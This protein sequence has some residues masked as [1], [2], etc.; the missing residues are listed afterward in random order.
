MYFTRLSTLIVT[1]LSI[2]LQA[3]AQLPPNQPEQDCPNA[4]PVCQDIYVQ[5]NSYQGEGLMPNEINSAFSC[6]GTA[7]NND[8]WY[9]LTVQSSG[10]LC[11][12]VSP[13]NGN[14]DYDWAVYNLTN[15]TCAD[16]ATNPALEVSCNFAPNLGCG[17]VTGPN[18]QNANPFSP[19]A[20]QNENCINVVIGETYVINVS[21]YSSTASGYV[22]DFTA[23]SAQ[24]FDNIPPELESISV[25]CGA[26][27]ID[28]TFSENIVCSSVDLTDFT[29]T[30]PGGPYTI[31]SVV[32]AN[33]TA[34]FDFERDFTIQTTPNISTTGVFQLAL[35]DT[36]V[37]NCG[38]V[39]VFDSLSFTAANAIISITASPDSV[40]VGNMSTLST[41]VS[42]DPNY[43]FVWTPGGATTPTIDVSPAVTTTYSVTATDNNN[44]VSVGTTTVHIA[45]NPTSTF[46]VANTQPCTGDSVLITYS[47]TAPPSANY[48][49][50]F[51]GAGAAPGTGQGPHLVSWAS[52]TST[53]V[54]LSV[55]DGACGSPLTTTPI[56]VSQTPDA[57]ISLSDTT[58]CG[59]DVVTLTHT[60]SASPTA[61]YNWTFSGANA[62]PGTGGSV[63]SMT[64]PA[65]GTYPLSLS[66][67]DGNCTSPLEVDTVEAFEVPI[68]TFSAVP[69][70]VCT[71]ESTTL[72][73]TGGNAT[74]GASFTW[75]FDGGLAVPGT[76]PGP[77]V[78]TWPT[79]GP[80]VVRLNIEENGCVGVETSVNITVGVSPTTDYSA[81][82][83]CANS[84]TDFTDLSSI[85][86][87]N[88]IGWDWDFDDP[89]SG[90]S[91]VSTLQNPNHT[92]T[93]AGS[94]DVILVTTSSD[95]CKDTLTQAVTVTP[96]PV[97]DYL[98]QNECDGNAVQF[99]DASTIDPG[100]S[101]D[102]WAW[103]F[104]DGNNANTQNTNHIYTGFGSFDVT[105]T[106]TSD[107][108]CVNSTTQNITV[109]PNPTATFDYNS[110]CE[111]LATTFTSTSTVGGNDMVD[112]WDWD[113]GD[114]GSGANNTATGLSAPNHTYIN[115]G[116]YNVTLIA[117]TNNGCK[118]TLNELIS[119]YERPVADFFYD[120]KCVDQN[121]T[122]N[123]V[124]QIPTGTNISSWDWAFGDG[125]SSGSS[126]PVHRYNTSGPGTYP[127]TLIIV[128][129]EGCA[130]TVTK[131]VI[132]NPRPL[133]IFSH[134]TECLGDPTEFTDESSIS[135]GQIIDWQWD[136]GDGSTSSD[137]SPT[138]TYPEPGIHRVTL[139]LT[140]DSG[141]V[142][143]TVRNVTVYAPPPEPVIQ[144][145]SICLGEEA[146]LTVYAPSDIEVHWFDSPTSTTP[147]FSG[148]FYL[149]PKL[150]SDQTFY[151]TT[152]SGR[153]C[154]TLT[155]APIQAIV[156]GDQ[157]AEIQASEQT[158][159]LPLAFVEFN[160]TDTA[161]YAA[162]LWDFGDG[163]TSTEPEPAHQ[164][165]YAGIYD[166]QLTA[167][168]INGCETNASY[169][170]EVKRLVNLYVPSAFTPNGDG[171]N[172]LLHIGHSGLITFQFQ[173]FNRWNKLV[174]ESDNPDFEWDGLY[175]GKTLPDG[176]Y[177]YRVKALSFD[178][179]EV[180]ESGT[181]TIVR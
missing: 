68:T 146:I 42:S 107:N 115:G 140:S 50:D 33:C 133:P 156:F 113:F 16:I 131:N 155:P 27:S 75:D 159:F 38:N 145:D 60:G 7:E 88:I 162:W 36:V 67:T 130:D 13:A 177:V 55:L 70:L 66:I 39:G 92:Y 179:N 19:C 123:D 63:Q 147:F 104:G 108:G 176:V 18:G 84:P 124:S 134:T 10:Q 34:G 166:V 44:C 170:V 122:F 90:T 11:F 178:G 112:D 43:T 151:I 64:F 143:Q 153:Q 24:V 81:T 165:Q 8:T 105:L 94:Y 79:T 1:F 102:N 118:D 28:V 29:L 109:Y 117:T 172:D 40:C 74:S 35:V 116:Q 96:I 139:V 135:S 72:T 69:S 103:E 160:T 49:W 129:N 106:V 89:S 142:H 4:I 25:P 163:E 80:K 119:V 53:N 138:Y 136:F 150:L 45:P 169:P 93:Q 15:A 83:A 120:N 149:T 62:S 86:G 148:N 144:D 51:G 95:G 171:H 157:Q 99:N 77:H 154:S 5:P 56:T 141:C 111:G 167:T 48:T 164:Y 2:Y 87:S 158:V 23:S 71:G 12:S 59:S 97:A 46:N 126:R 47:G 161:A 127:A 65:A 20:G 98:T 175:E 173:V 52:V 132:V 128:T 61:T 58:V 82:T 30:G 180:N 110:V 31:T 125:E 85:S 37:D 9:I 17:G 100:S 152:V 3:F 41:P 181:I 73:Y 54:T 14:D 168:D 6:L 57:S 114:P 101:I 26:T 91:N 76:G 174:F 22:L 137:Q 32:G 121:F 21:N 78:V